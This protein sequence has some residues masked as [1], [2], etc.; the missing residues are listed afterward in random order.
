MGRG[1][2]YNR[3]VAYETEVVSI[4]GSI[5]IGAS[6]AVEGFEGGAIA[7]VEKE[8]AAGQYTITLAEKFSR[9]LHANAKVAHD[10]VTVV[11][12]IQLLQAGESLQTDFKANGTLV[13]QCV[14]SAGTPAAVNPE[15]DSLIM[16]ELLVR[17]TDV[18]PY[19][20]LS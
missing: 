3:A 8:T 6:G 5:L 4:F 15:E 10:A 2:L 19:D 17:K 7:N 18:G 1:Y 11:S 13:L 12:N 9:L 16:F 14:D 20:K